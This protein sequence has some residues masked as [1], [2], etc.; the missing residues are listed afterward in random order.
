M[1]ASC[2]QGHSPAAGFRQVAVALAPQL[3]ALFI[4]VSFLFF[5]F[6]AS[7]RVSVATSFLPAHSLYTRD[8]YPLTL[9]A[10]LFLGQDVPA[11]F[12]TQSCSC[13]NHP[14]IATGASSPTAT[15][16][17]AEWE[18]RRSRGIGSRSSHIDAV[19][20]ATGSAEG[21]KIAEAQG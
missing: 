10:R 7:L 14:S 6:H 2:A 15:T 20:G 3:K 12:I 9:A 5:L 13:S 8:C 11:Y 18:C 17:V 21:E 16:D 1:A 4:L 19:A